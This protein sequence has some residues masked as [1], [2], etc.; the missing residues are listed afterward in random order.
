MKTHCGSGYYWRADGVQMG[1]YEKTFIS[2][3]FVLL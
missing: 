3:Q 2:F 1:E